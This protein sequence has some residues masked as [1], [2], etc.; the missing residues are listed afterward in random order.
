MIDTL[1]GIGRSASISE[2]VMDPEIAG[3]NLD[4]VAECAGDPFEFLTSAMYENQLTFQNIDSAI[5]VCEYAYLKENGTEMIYEENVMTNFFAKVKKMVK[6]AWEKIVAFFKKIFAWVEAVVRKDKAFVKKYEADCKKAKVVDLDIKGYNYDTKV[7]FAMM[8]K[9]K[10]SFKLYDKVKGAE[11]LGRSGNDNR[12]NFAVNTMNEALDNLRTDICKCGNSS[13]GSVSAE[14]FSKELA[15][16]LRGG[17]NEK[18]T[19]KSFDCSKKIDEVKNAKQTK[20]DLKNLYDVTKKYMDLN[21]SIVKQWEDET[22][23][24]VGDDEQKSRVS[25][26]AHARTST[27]TKVIAMATLVNN[28]GAKMITANNRQNKTCIIAA[29]RKQDKKDDKKDDNKK[30]TNESFIDSVFDNYML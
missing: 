11:D 7:P 14:D 1:F 13:V 6:N 25:K 28:Q 18:E 10:G 15:K 22:L 29:L 3:I 26:I 12:T 8:N 5:M 30:S 9:I 17:S 19:I 21:L 24:A 4:T 23:K 27:L 2:S 20:A 16:A